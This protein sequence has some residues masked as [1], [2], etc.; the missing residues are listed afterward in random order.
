MNVKDGMIW[1]LNRVMEFEF[2]HAVDPD[3]ISFSSIQFTVEN[4]SNPVTGSFEIKPDSGGRILLFR[5]HCPDSEELDNGSFLPGAK[6]YLVS[7]PGAKR[8]GTDVLRD[9]DGRALR[10]GTSCRFVSPDR[11]AGSLFVDY[12]KGPLKLDPDLPIEWP[13]GL[14]LFSDPAGVTRIHFDQAIDARASNI[15]S[16]NLYMLYSAGERGTPEAQNFPESNRVPG[17]LRVE[18]NCLERGATVVHEAL[19]IL[20]PNRRLKLVMRRELA[21]LVGEQNITDFAPQFHDTPTLAEYYG[22]STPDWSTVAALDEFREDFETTHNLDI[23]Q[24]LPLPA[25]E[26]SQG[27]I[28]ASFA[29][30]GIFSGKDFVLD[31][32]YTEVFTQGDSYVSDS[33]GATFRVQSGVL[34]CHNFSIAAGA[35]VRGRGRNPLVIYA[36]GEVRIEG[37]LNVS[38]NHA[39]WPTALAS[40]QRPEGG[41]KGECGGGDGGT[42]SQEVN[43]ETY[44]G[45]SGNGAFQFLAAGGQGGEGGFNQAGFSAGSYAKQSINNLAGG[46]GGG[47]FARTAN[48]SPHWYRWTKD[49]KMESLDRNYEAD[50]VLFHDRATDP[51]QSGSR[52][53]YVVYG[54]EAGM[55]GS[56]WNCLGI[57]GD[58]QPVGVYGM[59][60]E[61]VDVVL[62][63]EDGSAADGGRGAGDPLHRGSARWS[64]PTLEPNPMSNDPA[65]TLVQDPFNER[66]RAMGHPTDGP[67]GGQPG[68]SI[69]STDGDTSNDFWGKRLRADGSLAEGE[70]LLPWA[71]SGGGASG[72]MVIY[73]RDGVIPLPSVFPDPEFPSGRIRAYRKGA[74]GGGGGGQLQLMAIG[75]ISIGAQGRIWARGGNG[76]GG[77]SIG[78]TYGQVSGSGGGSGG[79]IVLATGAHLDLSAIDLLDG[80]EPGDRAHLVE[81]GQ[82]YQLPIPGASLSEAIVAV[83]GRRGWAMSQIQ[84]T[85]WGGGLGFDGN[86]SYALG[87]GG[88]GGNG[89]VQIH[90]PNMARDIVW[91]ASRELEIRNYLH[92][93]DIQANDADIDRVEE[94]LR[95]FCAPK[96]VVL[97]PWFGAKSMV[98]SRWIDTGLAGVRQPDT[99]QLQSY[100]DYQPDGF[101]LRGIDPLDGQVEVDQGTVAPL[102]QIVRGARQSI[103]NH[104]FEVNI[105]DASHVFAANE[106]FLRT[107]KLLLGFDFKPDASSSQTNEI[108][109]AS[110]DRVRDTL[111]LL[112]ESRAGIGSRAAGDHWEILPRYFR[113]VTHGVWDSLPEGTSVRIEFQAAQPREL[114]SDLPGAPFPDTHKWTSDLATLAGYRF[115]RY[116]VILD[117]DAQQQGAN[118]N[119]PRPAMDY[120]KLPFAW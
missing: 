15:N 119:N 9:T 115:I 92:H 12:R 57:E 85:D 59:E 111:N 13:A 40:P 106:H 98:R 66:G 6:R 64:Q 14:N 50:H 2:N 55:R 56:S 5:P 82:A 36:T 21:D 113:I 95:I 120:L 7:I 89:I 75:P 71:G 67:D 77:E 104:E 96:P 112:T 19:G 29:F 87:R 35:E 109:S 43:Q 42:S 58:V 108:V 20:P 54:G 114:G 78:Y 81:D 44:R 65:N 3:S 32:G 90:V 26:V 46:G 86:G 102:P 69:F 84:T 45:S 94:M 83:G 117:T 63:F 118:P 79:H 101:A 4:A 48:V 105:L 73:E 1:E 53:P 47:T 62:W 25:A 80:S 103:Q 61:R 74:P 110:Y 22:D 30:P 72:D 97:V 11:L 18:S 27:L 31:A 28:Q 8:Y 17:T 93:G 60:D 49:D 34:N 51:F 52:F 24:G 116:Q 70:L 39:K 16:N 33:H 100:P 107:P 88:A 38:G 37:T 99:G 41:A 76:V 10:I 23:A 91:P 68:Q